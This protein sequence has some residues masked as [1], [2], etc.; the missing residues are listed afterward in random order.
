MAFDVL[1]VKAFEG[2]LGF[3]NT[4]GHRSTGA[5]STWRRWEREIGEKEMNKFNHHQQPHL[6][7]VTFHSSSN[8]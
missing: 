2:L 3:T 6:T 1:Q 4:I 7:K 5:S 8:L